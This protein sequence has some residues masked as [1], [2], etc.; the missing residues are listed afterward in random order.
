MLDLDQMLGSLA[1]L[2]LRSTDHSRVLIELWDD[3]HE[4]VDIAVT[5]GTGAVAAQ[6]LEFDDVAEAVRQVTSTRQT[7]V[8]DYAEIGLPGPL[9]HVDRTPSCCCSS[10]P[11]STASVLSD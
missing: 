11:S 9:R 10:C 7:T 8:V 5:R 4:E 3:E 6:R 1:E 2:L